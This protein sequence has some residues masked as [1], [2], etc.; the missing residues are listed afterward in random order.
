MFIIRIV[1]LYIYSIIL[2]FFLHFIK[3]PLL[4]VSLGTILTSFKN[5]NENQFSIKM[6]AVPVQYLGFIIGSYQ[7]HN[8]FVKSFVE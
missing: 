1:L 4:L 2:S 7:G 6:I 8:T 3:N 5:D